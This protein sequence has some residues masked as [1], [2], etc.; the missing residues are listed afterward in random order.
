MAAPAGVNV[1]RWDNTCTRVATRRG[2]TVAQADTFLNR[3]WSRRR[4]LVRERDDSGD[5]AAF[6]WL[7]EWLVE[8][9]TG[10]GTVARALEVY[11]Q[12]T[13]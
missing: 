6:D 8:R 11:F 10:A 7:R 3:V 13:G 1:T 5:G 4:A 9:N 12:W 2:W